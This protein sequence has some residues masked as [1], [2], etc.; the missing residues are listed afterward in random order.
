[1]TP[2]QVAG[3]TV[4]ALAAGFAAGAGFFFALVVFAKAWAIAGAARRLAARWP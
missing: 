4:W 3:W 1:M 2:L